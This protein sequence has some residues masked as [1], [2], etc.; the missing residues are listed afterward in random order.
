MM[1]SDEQGK[2]MDETGEA[3]GFFVSSIVAKRAAACVTALS[4][5]TDKQLESGEL[6]HMGQAIKDL[7]KQRD[8]LLMICE[9][10]QES[11]EYWSE[12]FVPL[13]IV[14]RLDAAVASVK[15]GAA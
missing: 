12:Y 5:V 4:H 6:L 9:E 7:T 10:L 14:E 11:A 15:G 8:T 1:T 2:V 3:V 13:G